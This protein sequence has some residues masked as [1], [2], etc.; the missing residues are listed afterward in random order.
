MGWRDLI[1]TS[2]PPSDLSPIPLKGNIEDF[3]DIEPGYEKRSSFF[4]QN[5]SQNFHWQKTSSISSKIQVTVPLDPVDSGGPQ[6][7]IQPG[8]LIAY[9]HQDGRLCGGCDE[10]QHGTVHHCQ[11]DG[12]A[13]TVTLTDRQTLPLRAILS[14]G[15]TDG[16]GRVV[17]AWTV[18]PHGYDGE[19]IR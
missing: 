15:K 3:E 9:R 13:W 14:I 2:Q 10:R 1:V 8:W 6:A 7:P 5:C 16:D 18:R 11:W 17:A 4:K 19:G 12:S